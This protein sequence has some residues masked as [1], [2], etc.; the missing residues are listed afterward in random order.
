MRISRADLADSITRMIDW[1]PSSS[2]IISSP[3]NNP[4]HFTVIPFC[5]TIMISCSYTLLFQILKKKREIKRE[6]EREGER[7]LVRGLS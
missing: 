6:I 4:G 2:I 1:L 5:C 3:S 7:S